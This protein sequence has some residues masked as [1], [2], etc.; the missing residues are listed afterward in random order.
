MFFVD[1][2][3]QC[4]KYGKAKAKIFKNRKRKKPVPRYCLGL[5]S[6]YSFP[7]ELVWK[8]SKLGLCYRSKDTIISCFEQY[9]EYLTDQ[10][11][12]KQNIAI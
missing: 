9:K 2:P 1:L 3:M 4:C 7:A 6:G 12:S 8:E 11:F 10:H 5:C